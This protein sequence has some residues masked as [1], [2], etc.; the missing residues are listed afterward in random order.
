MDQAKFYDRVCQ[1]YNQVTNAYN[2]NKIIDARY[3][4]LHGELLCEYHAMLVAGGRGADYHKRISFFSFVLSKMSHMM[5]YTTCLEFDKE[6][7]A[8][9]GKMSGGYDKPA[10][11]DT[12]IYFHMK[13][14]PHCEKFKATYA[15]FVK[16]NPNVE[17]KSIE[18]SND[19]SQAEKYKLTKVPSLVH[20][21]DGKPVAVMDG[22]SQYSADN[23]ARTA[24]F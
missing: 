14:C 2:N 21:R 11:H 10:P 7:H 13:S 9:Q 5:H 16:K 22:I 8:S 6:L 3:H 12:A 19:T 4:E 18:I 15:E 1:A 20:L 17:H 24:K 23:L